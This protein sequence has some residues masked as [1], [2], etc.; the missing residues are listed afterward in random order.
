MKSEPRLSM[1]VF[2]VNFSEKL[3]N[4]VNDEAIANTIMV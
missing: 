3:P 4:T 2:M 1:G